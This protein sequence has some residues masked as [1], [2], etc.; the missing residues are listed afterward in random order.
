MRSITVVD[1][2]N[3]FWALVEIRSR[4]EP[5]DDVIGGIDGIEPSDFLKNFDVLRD[6]SEKFANFVVT[7]DHDAIRLQSRFNSMTI[8]DHRIRIFLVRGF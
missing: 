1:S 8:L 6:R 2:R 4:R 5:S 3:E 7:R